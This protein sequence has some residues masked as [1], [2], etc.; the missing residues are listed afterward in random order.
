[1]PAENANE[2]GDREHDAGGDEECVV[3]PSETGPQRA[4]ID[5]PNREEAEA[6]RGGEPEPRQDRSG[7]RPPHC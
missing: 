5:V 4:G 6:G 2:D 3:S 7:R 1:L